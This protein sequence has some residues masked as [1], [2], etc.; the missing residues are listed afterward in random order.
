MER[1]GPDHIGALVVTGLLAVMLFVIGRSPRDSGRTGRILGWAI[2]LAWM[3]T[4]Y[5]HALEGQLNLQNT[6]PLEMCDAATLTAILALLTGSPLAFE[7]TFLWGLAFSFQGLLTPTS[8][9]VFPHIIYLRYFVIHSGIVLAAIHLGPGRGMP[10]R[11]GALK[12]ATVLGIAWMAM[13]AVADWMLDANYFFLR[14]KPAYSV[15][16]K[17][18]PW[19]WYIAVISALGILAMAFLTLVFRVWRWD[20]RPGAA[21]G[22]VSSPAAPGA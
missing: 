19:P 8:S 10:L 5:T 4:P 13:A 1:F 16:N 11:P 15:M 2:L 20:R 3:T 6:L 21:G 7:L 9:E 12:R 18:G 14:E 22:P 17:L